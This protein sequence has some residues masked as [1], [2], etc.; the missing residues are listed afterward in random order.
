MDKEKLEEYRARL[1]ELL[2]SMEISFK[3][4]NKIAEYEKRLEE[5]EKPIDMS[6]IGPA[7]IVDRRKS[8]IEPKEYSNDEEGRLL[9][10]LEGERTRE[11]I[12][13]KKISE[14]IEQIKSIRQNKRD[15]EKA[16]ISSI[17]G[18]V[19]I[20]EELYNQ[21]FEDSLQVKDQIIKKQ[22]ELT[23]LREKTEKLK[24]DEKEL[25]SQ[26][27]DN[28]TIMGMKKP[29]SAV[30][31]SASKENAKLIASKRGKL[32]NI[33]KNEKQIA[34]AEK[35]LT[36]LQNDYQ[37]LDNFMNKL[38]IKQKGI[39]KS[40]QEKEQQERS[41][42]ENLEQE[43]PQQDG[44]TQDSLHGQIAQKQS[45]ILAHNNPTTKQAENTIKQ[46]NFTIESGNIP[47]YIVVIENK[48][49]QEQTRTFAGFQYVDTIA[50]SLEQ[51]STSKLEKQLAEQGLEE[52]KKF[53]DKGL[54]EILAQIDTEFETQGVKK[55]KNMIR[56]KYQQTGIDEQSRLDINYDFSEL[57]GK[58]NSPEN[59]AKLKSLQKVAKAGQKVINPIATYQKAPNIL[60]K[61][62]KKINTK[63]LTAPTENEKVEQSNAM[64]YKDNS[65]ITDII[66]KN[67]LALRDEPGFDI[68][69]FAESYDLSAEQLEKYQKMQ[70]DY[71]TQE[72]KQSWKD[73]L[74]QKVTP[75]GKKVAQKVNPVQRQ[76]AKKVNSFMKDEYTP[77]SDIPTEVEQSQEDYKKDET[78]QR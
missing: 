59:K 7:T 12:D 57:Y 11:S 33:K 78:E 43:K 70:Q 51:E 13:V 2:P 40:E 9:S 64:E 18:H 17:L 48:N 72:P 62:W 60:Q 1:E 56:T 44:Q 20:Q 32:A 30:Y 37:E 29:E 50:Y 38:D 39:E 52:T 19:K 8:F 6:D 76:V 3:D 54:A 74:K 36:S 41:E 45:G 77:T 27:A 25:V 22:E 49:G 61:I 55:Y 28:V 21:I 23:K 75:I 46:I 5:L 26:I 69:T 58:I 67:Y 71:E 73:S 35:E 68:H 4:A 15:T 53:Y 31:Q 16:S 34:N 47:C 65:Q 42:Q 63:L 66:E 24:Q 10:Q 14:L